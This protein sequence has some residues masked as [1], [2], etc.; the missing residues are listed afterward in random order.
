MIG[1]GPLY[2]LAA[3]GLALFL[4]LA[5]VNQ[6]RAAVDGWDLA[7]YVSAKWWG[8]PAPPL[9]P[10][11]EE[12]QPAIDDGRLWSSYGQAYLDWAALQPQGERDTALREVERVLVHALNLVP[13]QPAAWARLALV[14]L[15]LGDEAGARHATAMSYRTGPRA[16]GVAWLRSRLA[17]WL[18]PSLDAE[19][20]MLAGA[21]FGRTWQ[22]KPAASLLYPKAALV[23]FAHG[24]GR[25]D[26]I[27]QA[28]P[29]A[30]RADLQIHIDAI[31]LEAA[32]AS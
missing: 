24:L 4:S 28:L 2:R 31:L 12:W 20:R 16:I 10:N 30:E 18:W 1:T 14:R 11:I 21:D 27:R 17:L 8:R 6:F 5:A 25:I 15:N 26:A 9:P 3:V 7:H 19:M 29:L 13:A 23:R 32:H 22:R